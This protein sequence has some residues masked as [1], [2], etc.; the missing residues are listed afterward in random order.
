MHTITKFG[1]VFTALLALALSAHGAGAQVATS[2]ARAFLGEW[3]IA[4]QGERPFTLVL[5]IRDE[6]GRLAATANMMESAAP[7]T[8]IQRRETALV[9]SYTFNYQGQPVPISVTLTPGQQGVQA[10]LTAANGQYTAAGSA[11][12][13]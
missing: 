9:L 11:K 8:T 2:D 12:K 6:N 10:S 3:E 13:R 7:V 5:A 1:A 4:F